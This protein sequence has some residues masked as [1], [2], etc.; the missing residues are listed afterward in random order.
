MA[1]KRRKKKRKEPGA[2]ELNIMPFIDIFSML[3][4]FLLVSAA[5]INIGILEVQVPFMTNSPPDQKKPPRSLSVT[6]DIAKDK[7]QLTTSFSA[8]PEN[9]QVTTYGVDTKGLD[10]LH[11]K[12]IE[13]R[14]QNPESDLV[15]VFSDDDVKYEAVIAVVDAVKTLRETDPK[16]VTT[17]QK[18]GQ[19][20][21]SIFV[22]EKVV[23]GSVIL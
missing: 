15:S 4:T 10:D 5:F 3:N 8:P 2:A 11:R 13:L 16:M 18:T 21:E 19:K 20:R 17:D 23:M 7:V 12:L 9:K 1:S 14:Q 6:I 22:Y